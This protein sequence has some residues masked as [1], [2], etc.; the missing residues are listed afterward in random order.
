MFSG[1]DREETLEEKLT[2]AKFIDI[3]EKDSILSKY[4]EQKYSE[5]SC[6]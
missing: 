3:P 5:V 6:W 2:R 4:T 1:L